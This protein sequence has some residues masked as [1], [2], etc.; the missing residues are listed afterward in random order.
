MDYELKTVTGFPQKRSAPENK[1]RSLNPISSQQDSSAPSTRKVS[2]RSPKA[3]LK[4]IL[5]PDSTRE[6]ISDT[7]WDR[8]K[9]GPECRVQAKCRHTGSKSLPP[10]TVGTSA[11]RDQVVTWFLSWNIFPPPFFFFFLKCCCFQLYIYNTGIRLFSRTDISPPTKL[12]K[13]PFPQKFYTTWQAPVPPLHLSSTQVGPSFTQTGPSPQPQKPLGSP[14]STKKGLWEKGLWD[15][16]SCSSSALHRQPPGALQVTGLAGQA[17][18]S[19]P[20]P[21]PSTKHQSSCSMETDPQN[22]A[23]LLLR[24]Q[25]PSV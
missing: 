7:R 6:G 3:A 12:Y 17:A 18:S 10:L 2:S 22:Q 21:V 1:A 16:K 24:S 23:D 15:R 4:W 11:D 20:S 8:P 13:C 19:L 5:N 25:H 9:P 14:A